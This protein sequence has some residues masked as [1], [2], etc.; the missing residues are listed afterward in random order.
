MSRTA[1]SIGVCGAL[2]ALVLLVFAPVRHHE[3]L[4]FD[5]PLLVT[6]RPEVLR[7][8]TW[9]NV[10]W[11]FT[12]GWGCN[13]HPITW[14]SHML[15]VQLF[16]LDAGGHHLTS[17]LLHAANAVLLF[18]V[19]QLMTG[20]AA[21]SAF[22]AALFAVHPLHVES[23]AWVAERKD[24]LSAF[25]WMLTLW[26]YVG[27][28]RRPAAARYLAVLVLF[29]FGL[30][31]KPM[32]VT[33]PFVL[34]LLDVWPLGRT[35]LGTRLVWEK[36]PLLALTVVVSVAT[37]FFQ[38][39]CRAVSDLDSLPLGLRLENA[40]VS[41]VAYVAKTLWPAHLAAFYPYPRS[42]PAWEV[43]GAAA[44]LAG[45]SLLA[46][47]SRRR[48]YALVGWLW[49]VGT[50]VPVI[51]L[52]HAGEQAL[53]DR[54]TYVPLVGLLLVVAW[55]VPDL[56]RGWPPRRLVLSIGAALVVAA[57][58]VVARAQ[59]A[60]WRNEATVW[61]HALDVTAG[62]DLAHNNLG[63]TLMM[64]GRAEEA[65]A[66]FAEAVR[67]RPDNAVAHVNL[68]WALATQGHPDAA[69]A[70]YEEALRIDPEQPDAHF[71][72]G[73]AVEKLGR[74]EEAVFHL[75]EAVR[76]RP[77]RAQYHRVLGRMLVDRGRRAD[78]VAQYQEALRLNPEDGRTRSALAELTGER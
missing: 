35:A 54:F 56:L 8:L 76:L 22:V 11:A 42:F 72:L 17:V 73:L 16:G 4:F 67:I 23:V 44:V 13:W 52:V 20:Q 45:L 46:W 9:E 71:N 37:V 14:L 74:G 65:R 64:E 26:A 24:V 59:V 30:A 77:D 78:A 55:G 31:S 57:C 48:G 36:L 40:L 47:A 18:L 3:F 51:G 6:Q 12:N 70:E 19:L 27:Y 75:E 32:V 38:Q 1:R 69:L 7:G 63:M 28:A 39:G 33:L 49:F 66:H 43:A 21:P 2:I 5:D 50:L 25:F 61:A 53:A 15:D 34:L 60:H 58:V 10:R 62:N 41:Y 29:A 68:G